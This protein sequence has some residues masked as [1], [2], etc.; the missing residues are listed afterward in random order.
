[1]PHTQTRSNS[2]LIALHWI[3][4]LLLIGVYAAIEGR[5]YFPRGSEA[6]DEIK[7]WHYTLGL[8]VFILVWIR[9]AVR[10]LTTMPPVVPPPQ[11]WQ[12]IAS[13]VVHVALY[14][15]M[16]GM[17]IGGVLMLSGE[18]ERIP[19]WFGLEV[20]PVIAPDKDFAESVEVIHTTY[21]QIGY[22]LIALHAVAGLAH[23]YFFKDN[24]LRRMLPFSRQPS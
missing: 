8:T 20:P 24:A 6:R 5:A 18:G 16:I 10:L 7:A 19:F 2:L 22:A 15:L 3:M 21:G 12:R 13:R 17:P 11:R 1:M 4:L 14:V 9:L 23:H